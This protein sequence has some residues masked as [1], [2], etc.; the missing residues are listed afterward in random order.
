MTKKKTLKIELEYDEDQACALW[1]FEIF[2]EK[3]LEKGNKIPARAIKKLFTII[4]FTKEERKKQIEQQF[5]II[6]QETIKRF[7]TDKN[8]K[9]EYTATEEEF[10]ITKM[11]FPGQSKPSK[12]TKKYKPR[13]YKVTY[14]LQSML[15]QTFTSLK[16]NFEDIWLENAMEKRKETFCKEVYLSLNGYRRQL[17]KRHKKFISKYKLYT[18]TG[19]V[20]QLYQIPICT[21]KDP[22]NHQIYQGI[23][24]TLEKF[25]DK[26]GNLREEF[27]EKID[28]LQDV[29][30]VPQQTPPKKRKGA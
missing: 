23:R 14:S 21:K 8:Y 25:I 4:R 17:D 11:E 19:Y 28:F 16:K 30:E 29:P 20:A 2:F 13:K 22:S 9:F 12:K 26:D 7:S 18:I 24:H 10:D 15:H 27:R 5:D 3:N 6:Q 1:R